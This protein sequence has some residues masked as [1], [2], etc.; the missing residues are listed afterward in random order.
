MAKKDNQ[1]AATTEKTCPITRKEF[2]A[3]AKPLNV[4]VNG[5]PMVA[6]PKE[7]ATGS[8][9]WYLTGKVAV[10]VGDTLVPIQIGM[11][12]TAIGSKNGS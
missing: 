6:L 7:F 11:N 8:F 5:S 10:E 12:M 3:N 4:S 2:M 1:A 9:G